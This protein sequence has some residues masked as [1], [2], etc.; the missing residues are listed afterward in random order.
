MG[1][2]SQIFSAFRVK[3]GRGAV[4]PEGGVGAR[5]MVV[6][7][8]N[9]GERYRRSRH[10]IGFM[11][12]DRL[13]SRFDVKLDRR[14]FDADWTV[15]QIG[16][17]RVVLAK[18]QTFMNLSGQAVAPMTRYLN[19]P[20]ENLIVV[21]DELDLERGRLQ[22]RRGGGDAGHNGLRSIAEKLGL[23]DFIRVRVGLGRPDP[24]R[25]GIDYLL[26][27]LTPAEL[28]AYEPTIEKAA[29]AVEQIVGSGLEQAMNL[30]NRRNEERSQGK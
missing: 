15:A 5:W 2:V 28:Q 11:V 3:R 30:Y 10:N 24:T 18:P 9:P 8:G 17:A 14:R 6:G 20:L 25:E 7:L 4:P 22:V 26:D 21:H 13:A 12:V 16:D 1:R 23:R 19:V 27:Q 29:D